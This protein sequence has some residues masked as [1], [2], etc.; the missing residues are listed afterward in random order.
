MDVGETWLIT[1]SVKRQMRQTKVIDLPE[2][3]DTQDVQD[4]SLAGIIHFHHTC[5]FPRGPLLHRVCPLNPADHHLVRSGQAPVKAPSDPKSRPKL[6]V[7]S[8]QTMNAYT[9]DIAARDLQFK[10]K[11]TLLWP[12]SCD[13]L[14]RLATIPSTLACHN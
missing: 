7:C 2:I 12:G 10:I 8:Y 13:N 14:M 6:A 1:S 9:T 11:E 3:W 4:S 5:I